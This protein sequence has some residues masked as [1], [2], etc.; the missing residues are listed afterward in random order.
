MIVHFIIISTQCAAL[1]AFLI[2]WYF[3][4]KKRVETVLP[5]EDTQRV[6]F[7]FRHFSWLL[8][9]LVL[10]SC[11][12]QIHFVRVSAEVHEKL[13]AMTNF[14]GNQEQSIRTLDELKT[15]L[16]RLRKD[17]DANSRNLRAKAFGHESLSQ[18][19]GA[20]ADLTVAN[21][22][23]LKTEALASLQALRDIQNSNGFRKEARASSAFPA[24]SSPAPVI[25]SPQKEDGNAYSMRLSRTGRVIAD[26]LS[27]HK[28]PAEDSPV[29]EQLDRGQEVKVTEKRLS[30]E[31]MWFRIVTASGRAGWVDHRRL[32]LDGAP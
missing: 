21:V 24:A 25:D 8:M 6:L 5:G 27:I 2:L 13:A 7:P 1:A 29:V 28:R 30:D 10:V 22:D 17:I 19:R 26:K 31:D 9:G 12:L 14:Y 23:Q 20:V 3:W 4:V 18:T 15:M 32:K 16:E 11:L